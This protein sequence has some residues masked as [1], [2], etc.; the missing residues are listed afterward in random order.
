[1]R[2]A[3]LL[4]VTLVLAGGLLSQIPI[5]LGPDN[6]AGVWPGYSKY[7][8][9]YTATPTGGCTDGSIGFCV[10]HNPNGDTYYFSAWL[11]NASQL[12]VIGGLPVI[13]TINDYNWGSLWSG[14]IAVIQL[15]RWSWSAPTASHMSMINSMQDYGTSGGAHD[16]PAGWH[17]ALTSGDGQ[18]LGTWKNRTPFA[19]GG[20]IYLPVERQFSP[21]DPSVHDATYIM[22]PDGGKHWCNPYTY[23]HHTGSPGC[24]SSNW[25]ATANHG[26]A[27]RCDAPTDSTHACANA[28]YLDS[29]HSSVLFKAFDY[30]L[31]NWTLINYQFQDGSSPPAGVTDGCDPNAYICFFAQD[32]S[33]ARVPLPATNIM[34][35]SQWSFYT[36]PA[37]T[38]SYR[39]PGSSSSSWTSTFAN[40]TGTWFKNWYLA[41]YHAAKTI[42]LGASYFSEFKGYLLSGQCM[43]SPNSLDFL[44]GPAPY[45]PFTLIAKTSP[46]PAFPN[47]SGF[48]VPS[49]ALGK[50]V[51]STS[52]PHVQVTYSTNSYEGGSGSPHMYMVDLVQGRV[53]TGEA[54]QYDSVQKYISGAGYQFSSGNIAGSFPRNGLIWAFDLMDEGNNSAFTAW[55]FF[56]DVGSYSSVLVPCDG[57]YPNA[58][59]TPTNCGFINN[60]HGVGVNN[61][62]T[63]SCPACITTQDTSGNYG[64]HWRTAQW[65]GNL[66]APANAPVAMQGNGS[67]TVIE[68]VRHDGFTRFGRNGGMWATGVSSNSANTMVEQGESNGTIYLRWNSDNQPH[69]RYTSNFTFPNTNNWY[70]V[71]TAV[72]AATGGNCPAA[73]IWVA[74]SGKP[75]DQNA[76]VTCSQVNGAS[77][78]T[79]N[80]GAW[81]LVLGNNFNGNAATQSVGTVM[82][83]SRALSYPEVQF[84]YHSM[85]SA[86]ARRGITLQ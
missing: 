84:A 69:Y 74:V 31:D 81:P 52:P 68:V 79:P 75:V 55:P 12:P 26:D 2:A 7:F 70:F 20:N 25:D 77:T 61:N 34:N 54:F 50:T 24:D 49:P 21:G 51:V 58:Y 30:G 19:S 15:D 23:W 42:V 8:N 67:Y 60:P 86:M 17:G 4:F 37:I 13:G 73:S 9:W 38:Q 3:S 35:R 53:K 40:R 33:I 39:C 46:D 29:T 76:G 80:V 85:V 44:W 32:G 71:A 11:A 72:Q 1:M 66:S 6:S 62:T 83:Y 5:G 43:T 41:T 47:A 22:S 63:V 65:E 78:K 56:Q 45:G 10:G 57:I 59:T 18:T 16:N 82:V 28:A 48:F 64:G 27:P 14:N 36:C